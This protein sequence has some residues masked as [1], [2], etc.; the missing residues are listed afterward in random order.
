MNLPTTT[1]EVPLARRSARLSLSTRAQLM[2]IRKQT[3]RWHAALAGAVA[4]GL[5]IMWE[6]KGRKDLIAQQLFVR[7]AC[8]PQIRFVIHTPSTV[9]CKDLGTHSRLN[10]VS[11]S[12]MEM[13]LFL[14]CCRCSIQPRCNFLSTPYSSGQILYAFLL[15][16]DTLPRSYS[17]WYSNHFP[18]IYHTDVISQGLGKQPR[19][20]CNVSQ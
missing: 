16:P 13:C 18:S 5:A 15:R 14:H 2:I 1:V 7:Y 9:V 3:R 20:R 8:S 6:K 17:T 10:A 11:R 19:C 12:R 4:G